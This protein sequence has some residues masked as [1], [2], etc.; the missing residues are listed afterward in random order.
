M[1][2]RTLLGAAAA[3][4]ALAF[5]GTSSAVDTCVG[6][7]QLAVCVDQECYD[8]HCTVPQLTVYTRCTYPVPTAGCALV[9]F[10]VTVP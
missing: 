10:R 8:P 1:R 3:V 7:T 5:P 6:A 4:A 2:T 9:A